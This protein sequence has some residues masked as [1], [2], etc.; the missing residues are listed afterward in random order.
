MLR[1]K[2][3]FLAFSFKKN[4]Q[5]IRKRKRHKGYG[6]LPSHERDTRLKKTHTLRTSLFSL[7]KEKRT[8]KDTRAK[9]LPAFSF[10]KNAQKIRKRKTHKRYAKKKRTRNYPKKKRK[11]ARYSFRTRCFARKAT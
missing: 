10:K 1:T 3:L 4:A 2:S 9:H 5:K 7:A 6:I 11:N 8:R